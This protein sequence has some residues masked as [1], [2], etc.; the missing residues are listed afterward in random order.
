MQEHS[1]QNEPKESAQSA[2]KRH[3]LIGVFACL[4]LLGFIAF[5]F[6]QK[7]L[8]SQDNFHELNH[9]VTSALKSAQIEVLENLA[10]QEFLIGQPGT[11]NGAVVNPKKVMAKIIKLS[12]NTTWSD[13]FDESDHVRYLMPEQGIHQLVFSLTDNGWKWSGFLS[14][15]EEELAYLASDL[16]VEEIKEIQYHEVPSDEVPADEVPSEESTN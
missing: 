9:K 11:D 13:R 7:A 1:S 3:L 12:Q 10:A 16:P 2:K 4:I 6:Y 14:V 5:G 15:S 8:Q